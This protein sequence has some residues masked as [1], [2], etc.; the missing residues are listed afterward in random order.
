M[1]EMKLECKSLIVNH[2]LLCC[3]YINIYYTKKNI[4]FEMLPEEACT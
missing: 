1:T 2:L 3:M 4:N